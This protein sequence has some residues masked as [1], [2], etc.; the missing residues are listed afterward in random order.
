MK[1]MMFIGVVAL[2]L[3]YM[4]GPST[5]EA[6]LFAALG[7]PNVGSEEGCWNEAAG[8]LELNCGSTSTLR[9]WIMPATE[10]DLGTTTSAQIIVQSPD[11]LVSNARC[12]AFS[13]SS[14]GFSFGADSYLTSSTGLQ[15]MS[16]SVTSRS[17]EDYG[18]TACFLN[19][20]DRIYAYEV[21]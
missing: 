10:N 9:T 19:K 12:T 1:R 15:T 6:E 4:M 2:C 20:T 16:S 8:Y 5:V 7:R 18:F 17:G 11:G 14:T 21:L 3:G 13:V